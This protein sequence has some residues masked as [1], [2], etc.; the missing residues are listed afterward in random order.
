MAN[1]KIS[2]LTALSGAN[3]EMLADSLE[4]VDT[5]ETTTKRIL[6]SE[7]AK[8]LLVLGTEVSAS[9][10]ANVDF[11]IP[12]WAK[13]VTVM[14]S[15][16]SFLFP[17][18]FSI[19][20]GDADGFESSGYASAFAEITS[21]GQAVL[22]PGGTSF[23]LSDLTVAASSYDAVVTLS[24]ENASSFTW[25]L[26]SVLSKQGEG[27]VAI[28]TGSKSTSAAMDRVRING[29]LGAIAFDAGVIN[30]LYE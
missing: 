23:I 26:R 17:G 12:S 8:A 24:L 16:V 21:S 20:I 5:S 30:I 14:M 13:R 10:V 15:G 1:Q 11:T 18:Y 9:G 2:S 3:V 25:N 4:I 28:C 29:V 6:P 19:L 7:L 27:R 22:G